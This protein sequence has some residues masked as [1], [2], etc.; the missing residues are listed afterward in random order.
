MI[1][2]KDKRPVNLQ[3]TPLNMPAT[4]WVSISHRVSGIV[5]FVGIGI[6]LWLLDKSLSSETGFNS[7]VQ[8][9]VSPIAKFLIWGS[10]SALAFHLV[11]GIRHLCLDMGLGESKEAG[12]KTAIATFVISAILIVLLGVWVW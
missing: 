12:P 2:K 1:V 3:L 5:S 7:I 6:L 8:A 4:A 9:G 11:A 10:L